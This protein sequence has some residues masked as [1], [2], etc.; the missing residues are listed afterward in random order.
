[1]FSRVEVNEEQGYDQGTGKFTASVAGL[2]QFAVHYCAQYTQF[3]YAEIVHNGKSRQRSGHY[4]ADTN[5]CSSLLA[6]VV[7]VMGIDQE[8]FFL[9]T[10]ILVT[11]SSTCFSML[12]YLINICI[13]IFFSVMFIL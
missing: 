6:Y 10:R 7:M 1:M 9:Q 4:G 12:V 2:Y 3:V 13:N 8:C 11:S 5:Q